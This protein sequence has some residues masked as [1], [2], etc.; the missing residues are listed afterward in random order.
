[1]PSNT[2]DENM[3]QILLLYGWTTDN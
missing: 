1:M 3:A 2:R